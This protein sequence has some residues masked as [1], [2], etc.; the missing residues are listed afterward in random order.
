MA[1]TVFFGFTRFFSPQ[2][3]LL[4]PEPTFVGGAAVGGSLEITSDHCTSTV[5]DGLCLVKSEG[6]TGSAHRRFV[7]RQ[8][9]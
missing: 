7:G 8:W 4:F 3:K 1:K 6:S 5:G 9:R 2:K